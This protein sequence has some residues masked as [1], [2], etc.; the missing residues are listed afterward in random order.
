MKLAMTPPDVSSPN[1]R[2]PVADEV[3][4]PAHDLLLDEGRERTGVPDVDALVGHLGQQLAHHRDR[5]RRRREVAELA[6][7][8]R[9]HLAAGQTVA[10]LGEDVGDGRGRGG[11]RCRAAASPRRTRHATSA[12][13]AGSPIARCAA[14][15]YRKSRAV[16]HVS[17]PRRSIAARD[18]AS[19]P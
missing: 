16:A 15:S 13:G 10:E 11:R 19:S 7:M 14:W 5:Q 2:G 18:V 12:Y 17:A 9:V 6:R 3:A 4:Q 1:D 8:L